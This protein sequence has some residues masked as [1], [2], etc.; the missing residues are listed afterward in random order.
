VP[1]NLTRFLPI[2]VV[3]LVASWLVLMSPALVWSVAGDDS[4]YILES[5]PV[6]EGSAWTALV[7][8]FTDAFQFSGQPRTTA[9]GYAERR[10][11]AMGVMQAA[12]STAVAPWVYWAITKLAMIALAMVSVYVFVRTI[13]VATTDGAVG[14]IPASTALLLVLVVASMLP[15]FV[16][17]Q[18][19]GYS[20]GWLFYPS[21]SI[22]PFSIFLLSAALAVALVRRL[23]RSWRWLSLVV[24][25]GVVG[26]FAV[27]FA[28]E[29]YVVIVPVIIGAVVI[30]PWNRDTDR[31]RQLRSRAALV[32]SFLVPFASMFGWARWRIAQMPCF[33][34][35]SCYSGTVVNLALQPIVTS[36]FGVFPG[37]TWEWAVTGGER[38]DR[39]PWAL[40]PA[41]IVVALVF[42]ASSLAV[43]AA[44]LRRSPR[45]VD[46]QSAGGEVPTRGSLLW[47]VA[48]FLG[49]AAAA[50]TL[51][52][53]TETA[54]PRLEILAVPYRTGAIV[55]MAIAVAT[56]LLAWVLVRA[57]SREGRP[58]V[59]VAA[60][61]LSV[62]LVIAAA[63]SFMTNTTTSLVTR[64]TVN[65]Q[66]LDRIHEA[67]ARGNL[68]PEADALRCQTLRDYIELSTETGSSR[69]DRTIEMAYRAFTFYHGGV[70][71]SEGV[72]LEGGLE[73]LGADA[74]LVEKLI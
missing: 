24:P 54:Q 2:A 42:V 72:G 56:V 52:A 27:T 35:D 46:V 13:R 48:L 3:V 21:L 68:T 22:L 8:H 37:T 44:I 60:A 25:L 43:G 14:R 31:R 39:D 30:Q 38:W 47:L 71:C 36:F 40:L 57:L 9:L 15:A 55:G 32:V 67:V 33:E 29:V 74:G 50:S 73:E 20:N 66:T 16:T 1:F 19:S 26:G 5:G 12:A 45:S 10:I 4:Y 59:P 69:G 41:S 7:R 34:D 65:Y 61:A 17:T 64:S 53:I 23:D 51:T 70:Y 62:G 63:G 49:L 58:V 18:A 11:L 28:Y 6:F